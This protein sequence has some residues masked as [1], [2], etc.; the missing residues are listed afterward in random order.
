MNE[1]FSPNNS[2][3]PPVVFKVRGVQVHIGLYKH[4]IV[5]GKFLWSGMKVTDGFEP[6]IGGSFLSLTQV[7]TPEEIEAQKVKLITALNIGL[8]QR[9]PDDVEPTVPKD[10]TPDVIDTVEEAVQKIFDAIRNEYDIVDNQAV[11]K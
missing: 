4:P 7:D 1:D 2:L 11:K 8:K 10:D 5:G 6:V 9:F 3:I